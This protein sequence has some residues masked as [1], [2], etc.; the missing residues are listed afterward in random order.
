MLNTETIVHP[1]LQHVGLTTNKLEKLRDWYKLV[2]GMRVIY[3]SE[4]PTGAVTKGPGLRAL[5]L[6]NDEVNHRIAIVEIP[7][8]TC[9]PERPRHTRLQ[10]VAFAYQTLDDLLGTYARLKAHGILPVMSVDEGPQTAF[11]YDDPDR[12]SVELNVN[13]YTD[14]WA[15]IEHIQTSPEFARRPLGVDVDPDKMIAARLA[16]ATPWDLHKRAWKNEFA[17]AQ[18]YDPTALL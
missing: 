7:G 4:N 15:A 3:L 16:G 2:L 5:W 6:S 17:P 8:L 14:Q 1:I 11:Y 12:N 10:H 18:P 9:D 13:N